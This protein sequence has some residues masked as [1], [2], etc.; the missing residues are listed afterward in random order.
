MSPREF[1]ATIEAFE[2]GGAVRMLPWVDANLGEVKA[3]LAAQGAV[4][5]RNFADSDN[6]DLAEA[7]LGRI[8][9]ELLDD[10]Y[11]S[12]PRKG[13]KGKT[14]T[15]TEMVPNRTIALHS[16]MAYMPAWPRL[17]AFHALIVAETGGETTVCDIDA[18][19]AL[20]GD[21]AAKFAGQDIIY[22]RSF[23]KGI[24]IPW[25]TA[26]RTEDRADVDEVAARNGMTVR[27]LDNG[28]LQ[29]EHRAQGTV[30][31]EAGRPLW[32][33]QAHVFHASSLG[34]ARAQL[35][36]L[37]GADKLPR[38]AI[39]ADRS[40]I[41][42]ADMAKVQDAVNTTTCAMAWQPGDVLVLDNM[43]FAHGRAPFTGA[44]KLH[45]A[46]ADA[47]TVRTRTPLFG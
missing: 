44:R 30:A 35:E 46:M 20:M 14:F 37:V 7:V 2:G 10:A 5:L 21:V 8:G 27:W 23:H 42:D 26:F 40:P 34:P 33:N 28:V 29:T 9:N 12:T 24:D 13:V 32:F 17:V 3:L 22:Q 6:D 31:D 15:A 45:V 1:S 16:E 39:F 38:N 11:W 4:L 25:Q 36:K 18:A 41:P 47:Q 43:R 19:S